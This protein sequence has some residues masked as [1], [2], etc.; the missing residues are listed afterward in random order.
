MIVVF[1]TG[2]SPQAQADATLESA[3]PSGNCVE[4]VVANIDMSYN[5]YKI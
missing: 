5:N 4:N 3:G 1:K 2:R